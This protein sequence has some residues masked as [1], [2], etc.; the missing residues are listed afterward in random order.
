MVNVQIKEMQI[1]RF[2]HWVEKRFLNN[3]QFTETKYTE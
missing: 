2:I 1:A 3:Q